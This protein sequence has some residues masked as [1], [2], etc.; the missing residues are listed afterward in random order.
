MKNILKGVIANTILFVALV[1]ITP[2]TLG[3]IFATS[4]ILSPSELMYEWGDK[5]GQAPV[6]SVA[7]PLTDDFIAGYELMGNYHSWGETQYKIAHRKSLDEMDLQAIEWRTSLK[8]PL[9]ET[10]EVMINNAK[11]G[12]PIKQGETHKLWRDERPIMFLLLGFLLM[13]YFYV[14]GGLF[15]VYSRYQEQRSNAKKSRIALG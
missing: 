2:Y 11:K 13:A 4:P 7:E 9:D 3:L 15:F 1:A 8:K 6:M 5:T 12:Y 14:A 10:W